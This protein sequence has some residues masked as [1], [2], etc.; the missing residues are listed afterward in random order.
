MKIK[1][2]A[3]ALSFCFAAAASPIDRHALVTRHNPHVTAVDTMASL[4]VGNGG[5]AFTADITGLQTF[6]KSYKYGVPLGTQSDWGW[7]SFPNTEN[8]RHEETLKDYDFGRGRMEPYSVQQRDAS[9]RVKG[10]IDYFRANPHRLHLGT[11]G[12]DLGAADISRIKDIDQTLDMWTGRI[13]SRFT[14]D[15]KAW[16][17]ATV[18]HPDVDAVSASVTAE[19]PVSIILNF[20]YPTGAHADDA[21]DW[22]DGHPHRTDLVSASRTGATLRHTLDST[23]YYINVAW[24]GTADLERLGDNK[25]R[26]RGKGNSMDLTVLYSP[27]A[28]RE[29]PAFAAAEKASAESWKKF[30]T[31]GGAV[32]FSEC[33]DPRAKELERRVVLSQYLLAVNCAGD[34][35]P[36]ET[37]LTYNSW[38][39]KFHM[40]MIWW[41]QAQWALWGHPEKLEKSMEWYLKSA[42]VARQIAQRQG[43]KG[44]RWMKMTD[45]DGLEA[46]SSVG[47][48]LVW[49]QP[50]LIH[51]AE[52][53]YRAGRGSEVIEKFGD[54]VEGTAEF[55]DDFASYDAEKQRYTLNNL[56]PAQETLSVATTFNAPFE[57]SYWHT[58]L[59]IAQDWLERRG[60]SRNAKRDDIIARLS[61]LAQKDS[62]Y[63][64][65]ESAPDTYQNERLYSDHMA[66]LGALGILPASRLI[67]NGI[68]KNTFD[69]VWDNW[70]WDHTWGWDY[71]MTAMCAARM[72]EPAKAVN[73]LLMDKTTN[74]YLPNG[75]NYQSARLRCYLPGN[76][77]LLTAVAMMCAGWDGTTTATP[78][79]PASWKVRWEDLKP[80]P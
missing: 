2:L 38:Y 12:L 29:I 51:M 48:F 71:P 79:F 41:H 17:V 21:C 42:P 64:A 16:H 54:L 34:T 55:M 49:Q 45:P 56:I 15:G 35:P 46:P 37:G 74:I 1:I 47:S 23:S 67:D 4:S 8:Y 5:F 76:G 24:T 68:M 61:V 53:L 27:E 60:L 52:L 58:T 36:Q 7:H 57:L 25:W 32:D 62:L 28:T 70:N 30:W 75:H 43:F 65:A 66:V 80:L 69:W 26:I 3:L 20:P 78:G 6:P 33:N 10:A 40:E 73:S 18:A 59:K 72:G 39:G 44:L 19:S 9:E 11:V 63:L 31:E 13:E 77:G 14:L 22:A 50:H